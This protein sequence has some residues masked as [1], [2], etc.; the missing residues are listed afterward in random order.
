MQQKVVSRAQ[1]KR[2]INQ[3]DGSAEQKRWINQRDGS[4]VFLPEPPAPH[5][6]GWRRWPARARNGRPSQRRRSLNCPAALHAS[7]HRLSSKNMLALITA[8]VYHHISGLR[9]IHVSHVHRLS[10]ST[11]ALITSDLCFLNRSRSCPA[12]RTR[13]RCWRA[14]SAEPGWLAAAMVHAANMDFPSTCWP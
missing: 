3:R 9:L 8:A 1:P 11:M 10:S 2:W 4:T 13:R 6:F 5:L 12:A 7:K 14:C